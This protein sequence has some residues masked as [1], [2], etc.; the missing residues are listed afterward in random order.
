MGNFMSDLARS[1]YLNYKPP[2]TAFKMNLNPAN[3]G[4]IS[5]VIK[6]NKVDKSVD[7]S[8]NMNNNNTLDSFVENKQAL[9]N[10][11]QKQLN[12]SSSISLNFGM[13]DGNS[14]QSF[15][16]SQQD[17]NSKQSSTNNTS[18]KNEEDTSVDEIIEHY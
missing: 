8:M 2:V 7:I 17:N 18:D 10:A 13:Q 15:N 1:M 9:Q 4:S 14:N 6:S 3:L 11:L 16:Q 12:D 5:I